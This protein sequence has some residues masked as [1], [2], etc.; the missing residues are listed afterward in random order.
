MDKASGRHMELEVDQEP[1]PD[2]AK[3]G[4]SYQQKI[5]EHE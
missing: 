2:V 1:Q 4:T 3:V 5:V